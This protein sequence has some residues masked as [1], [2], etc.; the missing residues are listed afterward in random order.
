MTDGCDNILRHL[1]PYMTNGCEREQWYTNMFEAPLQDLTIKLQNLDASN[2]DDHNDVGF[3]ATCPPPPKG[4]LPIFW[5]AGGRL[6]KSTCIGRKCLVLP[7][8]A[9]GTSDFKPGKIKSVN[10]GSVDVW[11]EDGKPET[12]ELATR[13][14]RIA[15]RVCWAKVTQGCFELCPVLCRSS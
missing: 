1:V 8:K 2:D 14:I 10:D 4:K 15:G 13:D 3:M 5:E 9:A 6:E 7:V 11:Y 12:V